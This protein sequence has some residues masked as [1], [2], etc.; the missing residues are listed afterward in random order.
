M[1]GP[2]SFPT[3]RWTLILAAKSSPE[4]RRAAWTSLMTTYWKPLYVFLR[5]KGLD[6]TA[7]QDGVQDVMTQLLERDVLERVTPEKGRLRAYLRTVAQ[8]WLNTR[9][10]AA[11]AVKRGAGAATVAIDEVMA[12]RLLVDDGLSPE[13]AFERAWAQAVMERALETLAQEFARGERSGPF[14]VVKLFF[15]AAT[16][17]SYRDVAARHQMSV[18]QLKSFLHR[19]RERFRQLVEAEV[20]ET[21]LHESER[22]AEV[23]DVLAPELT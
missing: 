18:P 5:R 12:E 2:A 11:T 14:E 21:V 8:N 6:A 13:A 20:G 22:A 16:P 9:H 15:G 19:S 3:T 1:E 23:R 17:P 7:A 10:E 4:A